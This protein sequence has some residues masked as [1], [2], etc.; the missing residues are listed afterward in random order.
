VYPGQEG[1]VTYEEIVEVLGYASGHELAVR[2]RTT[3]RQ[4]VVGI[5]TGV[6]TGRTAHEVWLRP[7]GDPDL[8]IAVDLGAVTAAELS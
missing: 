4:V 5:P 2:L 3:D 6:D 1:L 7:A 8:E